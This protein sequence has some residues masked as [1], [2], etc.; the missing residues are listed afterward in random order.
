MMFLEQNIKGLCAKY[1]VDFLE[2]MEDFGV[3]SVFELSVIDLE[4]ISEEYKM[5]FH[6]LLFSPLFENQYLKEKLGKIKLLI[7]DIDGVMTDGGM[8]Y[9][10]NGDEIKKFNAKDG[11]AIRHLTVNKFPVGILSS[12]FSGGAIRKRAQILEISR[13]Y[14]GREA[15][16]TILQQWCDELEITLSQVAM[17]GDDINDLPVM[18]HIGFSACPSDAVDKVKK[19]CDLVLTKKGGE[20]CVREFIDNYFNFI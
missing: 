3:E 5:D 15:K 11:M 9:T 17:I 14:V 20:G 13:C 19:Q 4:S 2:M 16:L 12:G 7:L 1:G 18:E 6:A 10:E 8:Y